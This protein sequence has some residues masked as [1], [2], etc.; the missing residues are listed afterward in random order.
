MP[1]VFMKDQERDIRLMVEMFLPRTED[2]T[3]RACEAG[4]PDDVLAHARSVRSREDSLRLLREFAAVRYAEDEKILNTAIKEYKEAWDAIDETFFLTVGKITAKEW[5]FPEYRV[6]VSLFHKGVS[7]SNEN[8]VFRWAY[9]KPAD[10]PRITAHEI[11]MIQ[12]WYIFDQYF[13]EAGQDSDGHFWMLNELTAVAMLGLEPSLNALWVPSQR[14]FDGF[15]QNYPQ[16]QP[17]KEM[18]KREY[19]QRGSFVEYLYSVVR[20]MKNS[21]TKR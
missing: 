11:L 21:A 15:L 6:I 4:I 2:A 10:H 19:L 14:G 16:M 7:N 1:V 12:L 8:S 5:Q 18:V 20:E 17:Y 9:D 13:S 3:A